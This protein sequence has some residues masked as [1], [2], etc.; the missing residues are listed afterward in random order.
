MW[1]WRWGS[2]TCQQRE[3]ARWCRVGAVSD[4]PRKV[5]WPRAPAPLSGRGRATT[6]PSCNCAA[7]ERLGWTLHGDRGAPSPPPT[8]QV[9]ATQ[10]GQF[11]D[12]ISLELL[13]AS[14]RGWSLG[15]V[16]RIEVR[17][18]QPLAAWDSWAKGSA[19]AKVQMLA[20][21][22]WPAPGQTQGGVRRVPQQFDRA[23]RSSP[24]GGPA[25]G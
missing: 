7:R 21:Q 17:Q 19:G 15:T 4:L 23:P 20:L 24:A 14:P 10:K 25:C 3:D 13:P 1:L 8:H 9:K 16:S 5:S 6:G 12:F 22:V 18:F 11:L 2:G